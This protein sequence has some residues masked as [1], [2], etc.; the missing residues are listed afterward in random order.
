MAN[1]YNA[2][3][4]QQERIRRMDRTKH[5]AVASPGTLGDKILTTN[6]WKRHDYTCSGYRACDCGGGHCEGA[7]SAP[8]WRD[9]GW[10]R[11]RAR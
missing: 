11:K 4:M 5:T 10:G 6:L 2:I 3:A 1:D 9:L 8:Q 7:V